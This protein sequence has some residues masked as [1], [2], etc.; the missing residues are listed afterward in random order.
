MECFIIIIIISFNLPLIARSQIVVNDNTVY[1]E[2]LLV[3]DT[4]TNTSA[5]TCAVICKT[6][7]ATPYAAAISF[8]I[9][10]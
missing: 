9:S 7:A 10:G 6:A 1:F 5:A 2:E 8:I 3:Q 4:T